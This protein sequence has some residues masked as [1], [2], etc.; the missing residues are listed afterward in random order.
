MIL[1]AGKS[2]DTL[3]WQMNYSFDIK[4]H[5]SYTFAQ[6]KVALQKRYLSMEYFRKSGKK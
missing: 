6:P 3:R 1:H 2:P 4:K 5:P